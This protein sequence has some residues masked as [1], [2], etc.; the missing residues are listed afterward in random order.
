MLKETIENKPVR[1]HKKE[2]IALEYEL[3]TVLLTGA[4]F[5]MLLII[6]A[7]I[8]GSDNFNFILWKSI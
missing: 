1:L 8:I 6:M 2:P 7:F 3:T 4:V 5:I